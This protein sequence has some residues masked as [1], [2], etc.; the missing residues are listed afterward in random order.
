[1]SLRWTILAPAYDRMTRKGEEAGL[2]AMREGLLSDAEGRVLEI[3]GGTGSNLRYYGESD[4]LIVTEP[5]PAMLRRLQDKVR[6]QASGAEVVQ[7]PAEDLPFEDASFDTVVSTLVLCGVDQER[8]LGEVRRVLRPG[9]RLLFLEHVRAD[10]P[11]LAR[12]QDRMNWLNRFLL[13]CEC[14]RQTL[15]A[16]EAAGF[17]ISRVEHATMP[18][19]PKFVR[20]LV[21]GAAVAAGYVEALPGTMA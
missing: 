14:N 8:S 20:P 21:I 3:G 18:E 6:E 16:I 17:T 12:V 4:S 5:Q 11:K 9:G 2:G 1:M 19:A 15:A 7:A 10:D 13:G